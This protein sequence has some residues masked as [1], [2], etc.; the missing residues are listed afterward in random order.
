MTR[1]R[2]A[3]S[4]VCACSDSRDRWEVG[5]CAP[6]KDDAGQAVRSPLASSCPSGKPAE[7]RTCLHCFCSFLLLTL[8]CLRCIPAFNRNAFDSSTDLL[9]L[10]FMRIGLLPECI[11]LT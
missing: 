1:G 11:F 10:F 2:A 6:G 9:D 4:R 7:T 5:V 8:R 3:G